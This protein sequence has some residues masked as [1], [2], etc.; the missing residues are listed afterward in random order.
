MCACL[1]VDPM[2]SSQ[3]KEVRGTRESGGEQRET[4]Q[5]LLL[6]AHSLEIKSRGL[7]LSLGSPQGIKGETWPC[8]E[9]CWE[10]NELAWAALR[11]Q[12]WL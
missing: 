2:R 1:C 8:P 5:A 4:R 10:R 11:G 3:P 9:G 7:S 12:G 6:G